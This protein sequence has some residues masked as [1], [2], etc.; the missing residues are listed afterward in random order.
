MSDPDTTDMV[1]LPAG[2]SGSNLQISS[3]TANDDGE[4]RCQAISDIRKMISTPATLTVH[5]KDYGRS[6]VL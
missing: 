4:Y 5:G 6:L 2:Q 3:V 1:N